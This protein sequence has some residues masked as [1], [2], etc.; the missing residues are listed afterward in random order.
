[1][2]TSEYP[3]PP[4]WEEMRNHY[5]ARNFHQFLF[6]GNIYDRFFWCF[7]ENGEEGRL[8]GFREFLIRALL[9]TFELVLYYSA[10]RGIVICRRG[11][12]DLDLIEAKS[13]EKEI[14]PDDSRFMA[15]LEDVRKSSS[16]RG[17]PAS[18]SAIHDKIMEN[19]LKL[20]EALK[21]KWRTKT[22]EEDKGATIATIVD[23]LDRMISDSRG[24]A[25]S[26]ITERIQ[27]WGL[28][29]SLRE[30]GNISILICENRELLPQVFH[31]D[32]TG[33]L[34]IRVPFPDAHYRNLYFERQK[35]EGQEGSP[36]VKYLKGGADRLTTIVQLTRGFRIN[37]CELVKNIS[38][39]LLSDDE[40]RM[41]TYFFG[42]QDPPPDAIEDFI[43]RE[44]KEVIYSSSR[45]MLEPIESTVE[46]S[47]IGGL[48]EVKDY[49]KRISRAIIERDE[50]PNLVEIVPKGVLL[51]GPPG[52]GKTLLAKA[53]ARESGISLVKMGDIRSKWVGESEKNMSLVLNLLKAMAPVIVFVDEIDQAIG[54]RSSA[55]GDSGVSGRIFGKILEFMGDNENR[56]DVIWIAATNRADLLDDAMIRRFDRVIPVLLPGSEEEWVSVIKGIVNQMEA[57]VEEG[58]IESFVKENIN[59]LRKSHSG[60]S[61]EMV[62]RA[63][64]EKAIEERK[65]GISLQ[66]LKEAFEN[67][68]SNFNQK[69]YELQTLLAISA[70]NEVGFIP[71]PSEDY[72]Y[73]DEDL[74]RIIGQAIGSKSNTP[75]EERI[76]TLKRELGFFIN[77]IRF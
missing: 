60:S 19:L 37:D 75:L 40:E 21:T 56:G 63:A 70:C 28:D 9:R 66:N 43:M 46:F 24:T 67:F 58:T 4:W 52:T 17:I 44:K 20:E 1:M 59:A 13:P 14:S 76:N 6:D 3:L 49:F 74:D 71:C 2:S 65:K 8:Y 16:E 26:H 27:R 61:I 72:S 54:S 50:N 55:S 22:D 41:S 68:K 11:A 18:S 32:S 38:E 30:T 15:V 51:A 25:D 33:T 42:S 73:G 64:Y 39:E 48:K 62:L 34:P 35:E 5:L 69:V 10:T 7:K 77:G 45:G 12:S 31:T 47:D 29:M 57:E 36:L 53:L 23:F